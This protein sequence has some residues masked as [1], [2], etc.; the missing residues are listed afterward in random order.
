MILP[1]ITR[2]DQLCI[3]LGP[4]SFIF[5]TPWHSVLNSHCTAKCQ[6]AVRVTPVSIPILN[7]AVSEEWGRHAEGHLLNL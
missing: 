7:D 1:D 4:F 2:E 6:Y 3:L 5:F